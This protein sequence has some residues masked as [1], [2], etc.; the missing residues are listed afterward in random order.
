MSE[1]VVELTD[2][3]LNAGAAA[4][5]HFDGPIP[6]DHHERWGVVSL[7]LV[8]ALREAPYPASRPEAPAEGPERAATGE[9]VALLVAAVTDVAEALAAECGDDEKGESAVRWCFEHSGSRRAEMLNAYLAALRAAG[10]E[11]A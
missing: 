1:R 4:L 6:A 2:E 7:I 3:M 8:A 9:M 11:R 10:E 5:D